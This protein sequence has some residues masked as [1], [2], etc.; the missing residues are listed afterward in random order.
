MW[1]SHPEDSSDE[2]FNG[3]VDGSRP[4]EGRAAKRR[5]GNLPKESVRVLKSWLYNHRYNAY[6]SDQEKIVLSREANLTVL[7]VCNWFIN[8][9]RRILPDMI[10]RDGQ[11]PLQFTIT[12]KQKSVTRTVDAE[13]RGIM[14]ENSS[15]EFDSYSLSSR[16]TP[17]PF[18][19][20]DSPSP[21]SSLSSRDASPSPPPRPG[22]C[23][24]SLMHATMATNN[25]NKYPNTAS[26]YYGLDYRVSGSHLSEPG[27]PT[28]TNYDS[29]KQHKHFS[30]AKHNTSQ[31]TTPNN[32]SPQDDIFSC[33][34]MLVDVAISQLEKQKKEQSLQSTTTIEH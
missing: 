6:P 27:V 7:Q 20:R 9:R 30:F 11:D 28:Y 22:I 17:S 12:R 1:P 13:K 4:T 23:Q 32:A 25:V 33:F 29:T 16:N 21:V 15:Y 10:K 18:S 5:R 24:S 14:S 26:Y 34:H 31:S 2:E 3:S 19:S 8:A